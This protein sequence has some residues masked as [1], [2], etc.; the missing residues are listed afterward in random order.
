MRHQ[1]RHD[2]R[3]RV[4]GVH[5]TRG[6]TRFERDAAGWIRAITNPAGN[7]TR[8]HFEGAEIADLDDV[9]LEADFLRKTVLTVHPVA[10]GERASRPGSR[11]TARRSC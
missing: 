5:S 2:E 11:S 6:W 10:G 7:E 3:G 1:I 9:A 8:T 4:I